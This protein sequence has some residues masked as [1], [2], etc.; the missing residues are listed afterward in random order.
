MRPGSKL[1]E[2]TIDPTQAWKNTNI[3]DRSDRINNL[4]LNGLILM[5]DTKKTFPELGLMKFGDQ[6]TNLVNWMTVE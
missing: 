2:T 1:V 3:I 6:P 5:D 4:V